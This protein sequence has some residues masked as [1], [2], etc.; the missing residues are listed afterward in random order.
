[1]RRVIMKLQNVD[2]D[3]LIRDGSKLHNLILKCNE[4]SMSGM[5][6]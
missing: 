1:M 3:G 5:M 6:T 4:H 2:A